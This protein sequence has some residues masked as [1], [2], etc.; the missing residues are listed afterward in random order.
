MCDIA[1]DL[2]TLQSVLDRMKSKGFHC[3]ALITHV[4]GRNLEVTGRRDVLPVQALFS[5]VR[6]DLH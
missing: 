2:K 3:N 5:P 6:R 1:D 4:N